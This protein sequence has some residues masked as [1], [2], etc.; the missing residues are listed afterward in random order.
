MIDYTTI[1]IQQKIE[2]N[3]Q[4]TSS[5]NEFIKT[6]DESDNSLTFDINP[7][8]SKTLLLNITTN[9]KSIEQ[10]PSSWL[11]FKRYPGIVNLFL[12]VD[13]VND[14][15][16]LLP[17]Y[18]NIHNLLIE[19]NYN[20]CNSILKE[21]E[22]SKSTEVISTGLLRLTSSWKNNLPYWENYLTKVKNE[23]DNRRLN[24]N[25]LLMGLL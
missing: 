20:I 24:T 5:I 11:K 12:S 6:P 15:K 10:F 17:H 3:F 8:T 1:D 4:Y 14:A 23:L 16:S 18:K 2:L 19:Q 22:V 9:S 21:I 25:E 13:K 7:L